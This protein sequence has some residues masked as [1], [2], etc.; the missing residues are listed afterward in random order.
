MGAQ[1]MPAHVPSM[2]AL[3]D[4]ATVSALRALCELL[5]SAREPTRAGSVTVHL[6]RRPGTALALERRAKRVAEDHGL[7]HRVEVHGQ[8]ASV[9]VWRG[10]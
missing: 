9:H 4:A 5:A 2:T 3:S 6:D 10:E 1:T 7:R 8:S